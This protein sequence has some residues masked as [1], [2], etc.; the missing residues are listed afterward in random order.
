M[1]S[2]LKQFFWLFVECKILATT[3][4]F[5]ILLLS[6]LSMATE[7]KG[8]CSCGAVKFEVKGEPLFTMRV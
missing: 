2:T 8:E 6:T 3:I 4:F 7:Y 1:P 5:I